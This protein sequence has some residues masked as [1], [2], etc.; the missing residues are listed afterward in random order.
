MKMATKSSTLA[1]LINRLPDPDEQGLLS[2][3]DKETVDRVVSQIK[4]GGQKSLSG[5]IDMIAEPGRGDDVKPRYALHC[6]AVQMCKPDEENPGE[7]L[8]KH[9]PCSLAATNPKPFRC[10]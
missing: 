9:Y 5:L 6:L 8:R 10:T 4:E 7:Y 2:N 3:I 1:E